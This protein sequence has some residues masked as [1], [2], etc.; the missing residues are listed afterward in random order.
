MNFEIHAWFDA[1]WFCKVKLDATSD[2]SGRMLRLGSTMD[3][4][5]TWDV[6]PDLP[7]DGI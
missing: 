4:F 7:V 5:V 3:V 2:T 1:Q 6:F